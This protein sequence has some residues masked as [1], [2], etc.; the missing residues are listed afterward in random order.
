[1][2][3]TAESFIEFC[4][5]LYTAQLTKEYVRKFN[6]FVT[7]I[8]VLIGIIANSFGVYVFMHRKFRNH[9][10]SIYLLVLC[11]SDGLFL[12]MH[13][14]EDTLRTAIDIYYNDKPNW[15]DNRC[16]GVPNID[17]MRFSINQ[18]EKK[19][20][21]ELFLRYINITDRFDITCRTVNYVRYFLR[22]I[23]AYV[24]VSF[25][26]QRSLALRFP[27][28]QARFE[29][30]KL[31]WRIVLLLVV[32]GFISNSWVPFMMKT[33]DHPPNISYCDMNVYYREPYFYLTISYAVITMFIPILAISIC[34]WFIVCYLYRA[35]NQF[36]QNDDISRTGEKTKLIFFKKSSTRLSLIGEKA[37]QNYD[38]VLITLNMNNTQRRSSS[39]GTARST[40][41]S[42]RIHRRF[43][44]INSPSANHNNNSLNLIKITRML[45]IMSFSFAILNLP[46]FISWLMLFV[47]PKG[48]RIKF[49]YLNAVL[50]FCEI[51]YVL[52]YVIH[53]FIYC[54]SGKN[55]RMSLKRVLSTKRIKKAIYS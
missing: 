52:N 16:H 27:L 50:Q 49:I 42:L 54:L 39:S 53:F 25:T 29:S 40:L 37:A 7:S 45:S 20:N 3:S 38:S 11:M 2:N 9:S 32:I 23:N 31:V 26:I 15:F 34:N 36:A 48:S 4:Q 17:H 22:F 12:L 33:Q 14:F 24:I 46:Y 41:Y 55:F 43:T 28:H 30:N 44:T 21:M 51:F 6:L 35:E 19:T 47:I 1:M 13:L 18:S 10:S 5:G 8:L